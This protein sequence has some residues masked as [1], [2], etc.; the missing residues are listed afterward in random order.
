MSP[1]FKGQYNS[2]F[3]F[4]HAAKESAAPATSIAMPPTKIILLAG[5]S[6]QKIAN[7][8][9]RRISRS[10]HARAGLASV[11]VTSPS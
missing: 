11:P 2:S 3:D 5:I 10:R 4:G 7:A 1:S 6:L 8:S 9:S